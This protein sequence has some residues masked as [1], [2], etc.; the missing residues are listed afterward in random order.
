[1]KY[2][3]QL[4]RLLSKRKAQSQSVLRVSNKAQIYL[5][6]ISSNSTLPSEL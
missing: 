6:L 5:R 2:Q 4:T 3:L 1:M